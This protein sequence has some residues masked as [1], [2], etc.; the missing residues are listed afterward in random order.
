MGSCNISG[1][2]DIQHVHTN[3]VIM[4]T[5]FISSFVRRLLRLTFQRRT[6]V[7]TSRIHIH[8]PLRKKLSKTSFL[9]F[10]LKNILEMFCWNFRYVLFVKDVWRVR[11]PIVR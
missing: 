6:F 3:G 7:D 8:L 1:V 4:L 5:E 9:N 11:Y 10:L 2:L